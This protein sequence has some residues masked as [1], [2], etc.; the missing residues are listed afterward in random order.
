MELKREKNFMLHFLC[1]AVMDWKVK[2][3][4]DE[5]HD[6]KVRLMSLKELSIRLSLNLARNLFIITFSLVVK[7]NDHGSVKRVKD[8]LLLNDL[9]LQIIR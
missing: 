2:L 4:A 3:Y 1:A 6:D 5:N 8:Q 7:L 9:M